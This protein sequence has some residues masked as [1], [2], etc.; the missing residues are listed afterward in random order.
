MT[1]SFPSQPP[2]S[3]NALG[4]EVGLPVPGW[5]GAQPPN[6]E[7]LLGRYCRLEPLDPNRHSDELF[8]AQA[9]DTEGKS[10]TYLSYGPHENREDYRALLDSQS[11]SSEPLFFAIVDENERA[12]G[13]ASFL[14]IFPELGSIEIGHLYFSPRLQR[15]PAA[16][17]TIYLMLRHV[18]NVLGYRRCEWKCD[19]LNAP[20][21]S[22]AQRFGFRPEGVFRQACVVK[23]RNRDT[24]WFSILDSEW[25][26]L[27]GAYQLWLAD[28][29][30]DS[31]GR[32]QQSLSRLTQDPAKESEG[33]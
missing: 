19:S 12:V 24:A 10:W 23:G 27:E 28:E 33:S 20:S 3:T 32:Q 2:T 26:T 30:F 16:T 15:T 14:R 9:I 5:R 11:K 18:F 7:P 6:R 29:N 31:E 22:A 1:V 17:E 8:E 25:E 13:V 21:I 4:Q